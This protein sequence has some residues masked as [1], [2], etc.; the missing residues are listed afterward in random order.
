MKPVHIGLLLG[1]ALYVAVGAW[2]A[3]LMSPALAGG[4]EPT[5]V[6][7]H[8]L[9]AFAVA[10]A[11]LCCIAPPGLAR[12]DG[13]RGAARALGVALC[14]PLPLLVLIASAGTLGAAPALG[15]LLGCAALAIL[16]GLPGRLAGGQAP[17]W[18]RV[19]LGVA[20]LWLA[21]A[22]WHWRDTWLAGLF[23]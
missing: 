3:A 16:S 5:A 20:P 23:G 10:L 11:L 2:W 14:V 19:A 1:T 9:R 21:G 7:D 8:A 13:L 6:A 15:A 4:G 22:V 18:A 17:R 12:R